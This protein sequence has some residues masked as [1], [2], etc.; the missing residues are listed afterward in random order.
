MRRKIKK[1]ETYLVDELEPSQLI[2]Y[3][4]QKKCITLEDK[5]EIERE[6]GRKRRGIKLL[7]KIRTSENEQILDSFIKY[8]QSVSRQDL[9]EKVQA[10]EVDRDIHRRAGK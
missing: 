2:A 1:N 6:G 10:T 9:V 7:Q 5:S 4:L 8:L 3:L